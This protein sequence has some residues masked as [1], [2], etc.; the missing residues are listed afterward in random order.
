M[1]GDTQRFDQRMNFAPLRFL[2]G[3]V[4]GQGFLQP[5]KSDVRRVGLGRDQ[6]P[7]T[8]RGM[9]Q[10]PLSAETPAP[11]TRKI[12]M[13]ILCRFGSSV[14]VIFHSHRVRS[15]CWPKPGRLAAAPSLF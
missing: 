12:L 7:G 14:M 13:R 1:N 9:Y 11:V 3:V 6:V 8:G 10:G 2:T 4:A 15:V 5:S